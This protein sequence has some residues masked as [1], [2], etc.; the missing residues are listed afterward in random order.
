MDSPAL[1]SIAGL[2]SLPGAWY[3]EFAVARN[4]A[5]SVK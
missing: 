3:A 5:Q 4:R 1:F 2:D